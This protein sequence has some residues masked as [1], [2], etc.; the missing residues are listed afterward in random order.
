MNT[1]KFHLPDCSS[2]SDMSEQNK[3]VVKGTI[4]EIIN[5]GYIPCKRCIEVNE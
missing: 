5:E 3:S 1:K 2:V 4:E